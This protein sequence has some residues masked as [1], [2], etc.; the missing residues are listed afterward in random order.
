MMMIHRECTERKKRS[1][2]RDVQ[3]K[4]VSA[5][6]AEGKKATAL[7]GAAL[8]LSREVSARDDADCLKNR[9][10]ANIHA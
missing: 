1:Q 4:S 8:S 5:K 10:N 7:S 3:K 6:A 2:K 9:I